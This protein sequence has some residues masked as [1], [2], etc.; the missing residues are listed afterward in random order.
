MTVFATTKPGVSD[1]AQENLFPDGSYLPQQGT[2]NFAAP[3]PRDDVVGRALNKALSNLKRQKVSLGNMFGER[4]ET[5]ELFAST[6]AR[7]GKGWKAIRKGRIPDLRELFS[8]GRRKNL[9]YALPELYL[10][11]MY[12]VSPLLQDVHDATSALI[13]RNNSRNP[14]V[15]VKGAAKLVDRRR[16]EM[17]GAIADVNISV[18]Q[19]DQHKAFVRLDYVLD[20]DLIASLSSLG[21]LSPLA[22]VWELMPYSF[23]LDW[24]ANIGTVLNLMDADYGYL[25]KCGTLST[26]VRRE[27]TDGRIVNSSPYWE[28]GS[29]GQFPIGSGWNFSR[30]LYESSPMPWFGFKNPFP[31]D[32]RHISLAL[33][34]FASNWRD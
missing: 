32:G 25:F 31:D 28:A 15:T 21:V 7:V 12:G 19:E 29:Y 6:L 27:V 10:E 17:L 3:E 4:H 20:N 13:D 33:A 26:M 18:Q 34:L 11:Y 22:T 8:G 2:T 5:L 14:W 23:V 9:G 30:S 1:P 16:V 24:A